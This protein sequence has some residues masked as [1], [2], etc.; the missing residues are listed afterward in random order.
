MWKMLTLVIGLRCFGFMN[1]VGVDGVRRQGLAL[2]IG[3]N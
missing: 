3:P 2:Y 1:T